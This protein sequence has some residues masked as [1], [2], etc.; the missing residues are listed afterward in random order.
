M[1][2]ARALLTRPALL[3]DEPTSQLDAVNELALGRVMR[4]ITEECALLVI[5]HRLS[6]VQNADR[7]VVLHEGRAVASG[8]HEELLSGC[9]AYRELAAAQMLRMG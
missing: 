4:E 5:A 8:R 7:I 9:A 1:A 6:T 3:L 2:L